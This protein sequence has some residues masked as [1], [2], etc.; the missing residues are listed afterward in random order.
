MGTDG[1]IAQPNNLSEWGYHAGESAWE[2]NG[3]K[4]KGVS[5]RLMGM[6][7]CNPGRLGLKNGKYYTYYDTS[8][9]NPIEPKDVRIIKE[10]KDSQFAGAYL[11]YTKEQEAALVKFLLWMKWN[12]P[13]VFNFDYVLGHCEVAGMR[14]IG[15]WRKNDPSGALSM[16]MDSFRALL[17]KEY[18]KL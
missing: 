9:K 2:I 17:K 8:F 5:D 1:K 13:S 16:D 11:P 12:N 15:Y 6:E 10:S 7:M 3:K 14:G 4:V 18:A